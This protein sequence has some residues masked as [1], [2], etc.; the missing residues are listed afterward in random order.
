VKK[1]RKCPKC[2]GAEIVAFRIEGPTAFLT[3]GGR[4][5]TAGG[6]RV[7]RL[8]CAG[9]GFIE[10]WLAEDGAERLRENVRLRRG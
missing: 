10:E 2:G 6:L 7:E 5:P 9:C 1:S 4:A 3:F 8:A